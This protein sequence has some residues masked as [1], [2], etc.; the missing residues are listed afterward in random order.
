MPV[1]RLETTIRAPIALVFDLSR[2]IDAHIDSAAHTGERAVG[3]VTSGLVKLGDEVT[4]EAR[5]F[6]V[7]WRLTSRIVVC[8]P[9]R[10]FVDE[11]LRG[12]FARLRHAHEFVEAGAGTRM[13]DVLDFESPLG[14]LGRLADALFVERHMR[15]FLERRAAWIR[16]E[17][18][19]RAS[20]PGRDAAEPNVRR[21]SP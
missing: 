3:G 2:D 20:V 17:A 13:K 18:E 15:T 12:P 19:G 16:T 6:G 14:P 4:F 7:R 21:H 9:P 11:M 5:H 1:L 8:E 10:L